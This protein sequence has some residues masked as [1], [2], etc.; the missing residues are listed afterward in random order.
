MLESLLEGI[1]HFDGSVLVALVLGVLAGTVIGIIPGLGG[2]FLLALLL[3]FTYTMDQFSAF[4]L[5]L[6]AAAVTATSNTVTAVLFG[7]PGT[8]GGIAVIFDGHPMAK[9][10]EANRAMAAAFMSSA[11]AGV[12]GVVVIIALLPLLRPVVLWFGPPEYFV[13]VLAAVVLMAYSV[14]GDRLKA[15]VSGG[16]GLMFSFIGLEGATGTPRYTF[17]ILYLW[18]GLKIVPLI[19]GMFA[20]TEMLLL[21]R[22]GTRIARDGT[23]AGKELG[24]TRRGILDAFRHWRIGLQSSLVGVWVGLL[25][26]VGGETSQFIAY[27]QA[28]RTSKR[29]RYFGTGEVTGVIAADAA[30]HSKDGGSLV[31]TLLFGIPGS[32][33]M[34][35]LLAAFLVFGVEPGPEMAGE[36][37]HVTL[38][39]LLA[40]I[41]A[42]VMATVLCLT[43]SRRFAS[44]ALLNPAYLIGAIL[45][46]A[47]FGTYTTSNNI[48][49][50]WVALVAGAAGY[51]MAK[52]GFSR[53][54]FIVGMVL[55]PL[56][57]HNMTLSQQI[58]GWGFFDRP[59]VIVL[60]LIVLLVI[61]WP[62]FS[63]RT[64]RG[65]SRRADEAGPV[66]APSTPGGEGERRESTSKP[67]GN[68]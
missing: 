13:L 56:L 36:Q 58:H 60:L 38:F 50:I 4:A 67:E 41:V 33:H 26:G 5:L 8:A 9:K 22:S 17:D 66:E 10:G 43:M 57:E 37:L 16:L 59:I 54:T 21:L 27:S 34:A 62:L 45:V 29:G 49:D 24:G 48:G 55:G 47:T 42:H 11:M 30:T 19:I 15:L 23:V 7:V 6:A 39:M 3:P 46:F 61:A 31:P 51:A 53:A 28:Q 18:D 32:A 14:R 68:G 12:F 52:A 44:L 25:P 40:L 1:G 65:R 35:L 64:G 63:R 2:L 20:I